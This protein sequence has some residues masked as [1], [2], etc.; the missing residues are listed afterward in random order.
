MEMPS[1]R[2]LV[3]LGTLPLAGLALMIA[4]QN[5]R[6]DIERRGN[7]SGKE[8]FRFGNDAVLLVEGKDVSYVWQ[9]F[10]M[11]HGGA[12]RVPWERLELRA[13]RDH[14]SA[15]DRG[16]S[17]GVLEVDDTVLSGLSGNRV[18]KLA[19][20]NTPEVAL[21]EDTNL[22]KGLTDSAAGRGTTSMK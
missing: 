20:G 3:L 8:L 13:G 4:C 9:G 22:A 18:A 21:T 7:F 10:N 19:V 11:R 15:T 14:H 5:Q 16:V 1:I 17:N 6:P 2:R 12:T